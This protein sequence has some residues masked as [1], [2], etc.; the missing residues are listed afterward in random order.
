MGRKAG[1]T[2]GSRA[3]GGSC[4]SGASVTSSA[5]ARIAALEQEL[6]A[7]KVETEQLQKTIT[8]MKTGK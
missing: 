2:A 3:G 6:A 7:A 4:A 8:A 1:G 5:I